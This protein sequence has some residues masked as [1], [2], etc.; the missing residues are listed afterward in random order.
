MVVRLPKT[1]LRT[2]SPETEEIAKGIHTITQALPIDVNDA[3]VVKT[4][5]PGKEFGVPVPRSMRG[6]RPRWYLV[7]YQN[8]PGVIWASRGSLSDGQTIWLRSSA[9][10]GVTFVLVPFAGASAPGVG[11]TEPPGPNEDAQPE[12]EGQS[13]PSSTVN[14]KKKGKKWKGGK[15]K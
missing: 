14:T 2:R 11:K 4:P 1:P 15:G 3:V 8:G 12:E 10:A 13:S 7:V 6:V 5:S 9:P